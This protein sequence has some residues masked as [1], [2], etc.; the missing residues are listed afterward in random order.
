MQETLSIILGLLVLLCPSLQSDQGRQTEAKLI[1]RF[2]GF[3]GDYGISEAVIDFAI[4][5]HGSGDMAA[6]RLCS[7]QPLPLALFTAAANPFVVVERVSDKFSPDHILFLRSEDC[8]GSHSEVATELWAIPVGSKP[9]SFVESVKS[10]EVRF[11]SIGAKKGP[12]AYGARNYKAAVK[13]LSLKL[14]EKPETT[15]VIVGYYYKTPSNVMKRRIREVQ[16]MLQQSGLPRDRYLV[17]LAPWTGEYGIDPPDPEPQ[18]PNVF[19]V[20]ISGTARI[21]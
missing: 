6:V 10:S 18:Y 1:H 16:R 5:P 19:I 17:R 20:E 12:T 13:H 9:P 15:G 3:S 7:N 4:Y 21:R 14:R 2:E 11:R 8:V